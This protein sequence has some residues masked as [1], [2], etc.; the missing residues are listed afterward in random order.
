MKAER[1]SFVISC[2]QFCFPFVYPEPASPP[3][4]SSH[5][6]STVLDVFFFSLFNKLVHKLS[7]IKD[8]FFNYKVDRDNKTNK[9][10]IV[11]SGGRGLILANESSHYGGERNQK[12]GGGGSTSN[13]CWLIVPL[14]RLLSS[15]S[16]QNDSLWIPKAHAA[17]N[18]RG[19]VCP[20]SPVYSTW[21]KTERERAWRG[22]N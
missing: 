8:L 11:E 16:Q 17:E 1:R 15:G 7:H 10:K 9:D 18:M 4:S 20:S 2:L 3:T 12:W 14:C 21:F 19:N 5:G 6:T 22:I 13:H